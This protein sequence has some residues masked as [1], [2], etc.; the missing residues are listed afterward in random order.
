MNN[1][2]R[3]AC[4]VHLR[5][6]A[7]TERTTIRCPAPGRHPDVTESI[8]KAPASEPIR[9]QASAVIGTAALRLMRPTFLRILHS[10]DPQASAPIGSHA[11]S[12]IAGLSSASRYSAGSIDLG[13]ATSYTYSSNHG[14]SIVK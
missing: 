1:A 12:M 10:Q 11:G 2:G 5:C 7:A 3:V 9:P 4:T 8:R 6:G 14:S 13:T